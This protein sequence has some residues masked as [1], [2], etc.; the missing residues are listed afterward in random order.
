M[1]QILKIVAVVVGVFLAQLYLAEA[2]EV[3]QI[4]PDF[5]LVL[6][7]YIS[8]RYG[9]IPG[10]LF[11]FTAGLLQDAMGSLSVLGAN[12]LAKSVIGYTLG[13]LNGTLAVWTPR[14][15]NVYVYGTL[16]GHAIIYQTV[17]SQGLDL[18]IGMLLARIGLEAFISS[19][20]VT[21][22][23]FLFPLVPSQ[24]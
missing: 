12:A 16:L 22:L 14:I 10:I 21:G 4:R 18:P 15:V 24:V 19:V 9:R 7:V 8:A 23:R 6:L 11:G 17:M 13:T 20:I 2:M 5:I 1:S 3:W